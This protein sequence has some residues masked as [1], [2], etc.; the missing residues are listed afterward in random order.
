MR[1]KSYAKAEDRSWWKPFDLS[2]VDLAREDP[3]ARQLEHFSAVARGEAEP[4]VTV[5]DGLANLRVTEAIVE[6][7]RSGCAVDLPQDR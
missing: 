4:L 1:I 3:L 2:V 5:R 6:A 7:V